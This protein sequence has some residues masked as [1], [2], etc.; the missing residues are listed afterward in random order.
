[1][2]IDRDV[3]RRI[4]ERLAEDYPRTVVADFLYEG[5]DNPHD[6]LP[7]V[8]YLEDHG[9]VTAFYGGPKAMGNNPVNATITAKGLDFLADDGGL[10]AILGV[11]TI[12]V[13]EDSL[14]KLVAARID[15]AGLPPQEKK[16]F[17]DQLQ[18]LPGKTTE[19][20]VLKLVDAGLDNWPKAWALLQSMVS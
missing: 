20:L 4:L 5:L 13:H 14:T 16:A 11:V 8:S 9:L 2:K 6:L 12:K 19:H 1:M 7:T 3:Q 17:L 18:K 10:G 15:A